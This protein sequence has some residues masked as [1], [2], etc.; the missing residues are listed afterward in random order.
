ME[1][2]IKELYSAMVFFGKAKEIQ[3]SAI[4]II[5]NLPISHSGSNGVTG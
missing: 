3:V 2:E 1:N 4:H 5:A